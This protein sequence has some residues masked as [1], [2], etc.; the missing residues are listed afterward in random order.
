MDIHRCG[1]RPNRAASPDWFVGEVWQTP[2]HEAPAPARV[3]TALVRFSPGARTNWHTHPLGQTLY[4]TEGAGLVQTR[5][6][7]VRRIRAGDVVWFAPGEMHWHGA[8]PGT[9]MSHVAVHEAEDGRSA[10]WFEPVSD[11]ERWMIRSYEDHLSG[12]A[13][14]RPRPSEP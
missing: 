11:A 1:D 8:A 3:R 2:I 7:P 13:P 5:G 12:P 14:R 9:G 4:V 6:G 10:D